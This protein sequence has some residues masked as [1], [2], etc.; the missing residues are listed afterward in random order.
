MATD[1]PDTDTGMD[2]VHGILGVLDMDPAV[3]VVLDTD[4]AVPVTGRGERRDSAVSGKHSL[5]AIINRP[6]SSR[7]V[8]Y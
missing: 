2:M 4:L 7:A 5:N 3:L 8:Y 6:D 1:I